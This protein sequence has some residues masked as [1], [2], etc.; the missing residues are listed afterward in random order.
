MDVLKQQ[1]LPYLKTNFEKSL[2]EAALYNLNEADNKL[3]LNNFA[4]AVRELTRHFLERLAPDEEVLS[5]PWFKPNDP[6]NPK[7][8]TRAQRIKYAIQGYL[9]DDFTKNV[10]LIN[11]TEVSDNLKTSIDDLSKYTHVNPDTFDSGADAIEVR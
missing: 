8:I 9:S 1:I 11:L 6:D 5:A 2:F 3:R 4:C 7:K 10:L